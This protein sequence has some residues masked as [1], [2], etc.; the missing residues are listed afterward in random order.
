M[1][2]TSECT[3]VSKSFKVEGVKNSCLYHYRALICP[4]I[5]YGMKIYFY[6]AD[7]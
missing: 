1:L 3:Q 7:S 5:E 6:S 2:Q 4:I